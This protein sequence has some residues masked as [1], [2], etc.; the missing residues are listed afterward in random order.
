[1]MAQRNVLLDCMRGAAIVLVVLGHAG[2]NAPLWTFIYAF[3]MPLFFF[4]SG[5]FCNGKRG[6]GDFLIKK[7]KTLYLPFVKYYVLFILISR[8]LHQF[9]ITKFDYTSGIDI[10]QAIFL[11]CRFRVGAMDLLGHFWFLPVLFFISV[12]VFLSVKLVERY[13]LSSAYVLIGGG[14]SYNNRRS[15]NQ[16]FFAESV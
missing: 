14:N 2:I 1:M 8:F 13:S 15:G 9:R 16:V 4:I 7:I 6:V 12:L 3:H 10:L 5:F 11:A